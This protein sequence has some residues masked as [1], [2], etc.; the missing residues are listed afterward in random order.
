[1]NQKQRISLHLE[2]ILCSRD[3]IPLSSPPAMSSSKIINLETETK[4]SNTGSQG[5]VSREG[6]PPSQ[7][8]SASESRRGR[9]RISESV[10]VSKKQNI[11]YYWKN[12]E[13]LKLYIVTI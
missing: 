7:K 3:I 8:R 11:K 10:H 9:R 6:I 1:V 12:E 4:E 13:L 5:T 2:D